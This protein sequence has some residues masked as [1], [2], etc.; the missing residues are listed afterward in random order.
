MRTYT[1]RFHTCFV[2]CYDPS[3]SF[4]FVMHEE[5]CVGTPSAPVICFYCF[6][7]LTQQCVVSELQGYGWPQG[8][9]ESQRW[10]YQISAGWRRSNWKDNLTSLCWDSSHCMKSVHR[11]DKGATNKSVSV[12]HVQP[13]LL[14][15]SY[16]EFQISHQTNK[17]YFCVFSNV[18]NCKAKASVYCGCLLHTFAQALYL[19]QC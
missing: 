7:V 19:S 2:L 16:Y 10:L 1:E 12:A 4:I 5:I 17:D 14:V 9:P 11:C 3:Y 15:W 18:N 6:N 8:L 13:L